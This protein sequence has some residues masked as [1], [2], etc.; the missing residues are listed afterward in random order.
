MSTK[1]SI[2]FPKGRRSFINRQAATCLLVLF[3]I[4]LLPMLHSGV[5]AQVKAPSDRI[6]TYQ[7]QI[8][9]AGTPVP[10]GI[11]YLTASLYS[12][13]DGRARLWTS[14]YAAEVRNGIANLSLGEVGVNA[15][16]LPE[17]G[18]DGPL[19]LGISVGSNTAEVGE[20]MRPLTRLSSSVNALSVADNSIT[21]QKL[22]TSYV[23]KIV[24]NGDTINGKGSTFELDAGPGIKF[25]RTGVSRYH[26]GTRDN[27]VNASSGTPWTET[28][29]Y[30][31][32]TTAYLGTSDA[33]PLPIKVNATR[34]MLYSPTTN[35]VNILGGSASNSITAGEGVTI[36]GGGNGTNIN[37]ADGDYSTISGGL[38]NSVKNVSALAGGE[39]NQA[40]GQWAALGGGYHNKS[41]YYYTTV[42]GGT[43]N[44]ITTSGSQGSAIGGGT[45]NTITGENSVISG[46]NTNEIVGDYS[47]IAGGLEL[48]L[49]DNSFGFNG[50]VQPVDLSLTPNVAYFGDV[51]VWIKS[52]DPSTSKVP[53]Q[54]RFYQ[55]LWAS[56]DY[57]TSFRA[58]VGL[59]GNVEYTLPSSQGA[60]GTVLTN[61]GS[62]TLSWGSS[63]AGDWRLT[64]N[65]GTFAGPNY[66]GTNDNQAFEIHVD[67]AGSSTQGRRRVARFEPTATSPNVIMGQNAN[68]NTSSYVGTSIT[69]GGSATQ[70]NLTNGDYASIG[71]GLDNQ[72]TSYSHIGGGYSHD[73]AS[74][75]SSIS[76]GKNNEIKTAGGYSFIGG[77]ENNDV[78]DQ[79]SVV[80]GGFS[81]LTKG[82]NSFIGGGD[83]NLIEALGKYG[84]IVGGH[85]NASNGT[86][87]FVGGGGTREHIE[88]FPDPKSNF[89]GGHYSVVVG[90]SSNVAFGDYSYVGGGGYDVDDTTGRTDNGNIADLDYSTVVGGSG[91]RARGLFS[92]VGGG[93]DDATDMLMTDS[94]SAQGRFSVVV[95]GSANRAHGDFS[96]VGGGG[97]DGNTLSYGD[98]NSAY[99]NYSVVV[100][101][102]KNWARSTLSTIGGGGSNKI[103]FSSG[104]KGDAHAATIAGGESNTIL[105]GSTGSTGYPSY[106]ATISGGGQNEALGQY[107]T[108]GGGAM[109]KAHHNHTMIGGGNDNVA[110]A[111]YGTISG[112]QGNHANGA[113]TFIGGGSG[114]FA[115]ANRAVVAGG[116]GNKAQSNYSAIGGGLSNIIS[117]AVPG[118]GLYANIPGGVGLQSQS[119]AQTVI[120][121]S[122][123]VQGTRTGP[124]VD[125]DRLFII[126]N[127]TSPAVTDRSNAFEVSSNGHSIVFDEKN[128]SAPAAKPIYGATYTDNIIYA[129]GNIPAGGPTPQ[130]LIPTDQFGIAGGV[131]FTPPNKYV[132]TL[133]LEDPYGSNRILNHGSVTATIICNA[134]T[135]PGCQTISVSPLAGNSFTVYTHQVT[136][137]VCDQKPL[138]FNFKVTGRP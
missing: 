13:A 92:F 9:K 83:H 33:S 49:G 8:L 47:A 23:E 1:T 114:N 26:I 53:N 36:A 80:V 42:A 119:Y 129:W 30:S 14:R 96:F 65:T 27:G 90:G 88:S 20:E 64:G 37:T 103:E 137:A 57:Y 95:G 122:N 111:Q 39:G 73:V 18:L 46:G 116:T 106:Y 70:P 12:D 58:P 17:E 15:Q 118:S 89:A 19:Y 44:E 100:G 40:E 43:Q 131:V 50:I 66:L 91:N 63:S 127:G 41:N 138:P 87:S 54:L 69:G 61:N 99:G 48:T 22:N 2:S 109:N 79:Y 68:G 4:G 98:S 117:D 29:N 59:S 16:P 112:G 125:N 76:G 104:A 51:D 28:G 11:Y 93:G 121:H 124:A 82:L 84:V 75:Y 102:R 45:N 130:V 86:L 67:E 72:A 3:A 97:N 123:K 126:G 136:G 25:A 74:S 132:V 35:S 60:T 5:L 110:D 10:D 62:G 32:A 135:D 134:E 31:L 108:V 94:N 38:G 55:S 6:I 113:N 105:D 21:K 77:G 24:I 34:A 71:G 78:R 56:G 52:A 101:G 81:H 107:A 7:A 120:G 133:H 128:T 115:T 85:H